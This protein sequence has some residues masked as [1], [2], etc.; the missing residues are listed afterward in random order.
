M[1]ASWYTTSPPTTVAAT[2]ILPISCGASCRG[3]APSITRSPSLPTSIVPFTRSSKAP[4]AAFAVTVE[5]ASCTAIR[6]GS[7]STLPELVTRAERGELRYGGRTVKVGAFPISIDAGALD[8]LARTPEVQ[9]RA[10]AIR[11][12]L[13]DPAQC[14]SAST[15]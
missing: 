4:R 5:S 14:C 2:G 7:F 11:A 8:E 10:K 9:E 15:G 3:L 13:G 6:S 1:A 12:D